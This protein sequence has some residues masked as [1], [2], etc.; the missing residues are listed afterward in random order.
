MIAESDVDRKAF[1][2]FRA[3]AAFKGYT[4]ARSNPSDGPVSYWASRW[5]LVRELRTL[6][7][8]GAFIQQIGAAP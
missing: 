2:T 1:E 6:A 7:D 3:A 8:V 5:G 4:L